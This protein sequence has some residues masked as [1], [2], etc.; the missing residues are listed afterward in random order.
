MIKK[1]DL[2]SIEFD[3]YYNSYSNIVNIDEFYG[4][5]GR[6][7]Y[8]LLAHLSTLF[9]NVDIID[10]STHMGSSSL[11][12]SYNKLN[13]VYTFD[14]DNRISDENK[15][16]FPGN[17]KFNYLNLF[18]PGTQLEWSDKILSSPLIFLDIDPHDG[19]LEY[20][21]YLF[22]K[23]NNY[24][25]LL[26]LDN[27]W[28]FKKMRDN[29]WYK[30]PTEDKLDITNMGHW[31][32]TGLVQFNKSKEFE[33]FK[34][35]SLS[36]QLSQILASPSTSPASSLPQETSPT[37]V[38]AYFDLT[39]MKDAS[40]EINN[41]PLMH[42]LDSSY[43]TL[44]LD[45]N[46]IIYCEE[47]NIEIIKK[48]RPDRL[49]SRTKFIIQHF[50]DFQI[51]G[52]TFDKYRDMIIKNRK[53]ILPSKDGRNTASY[54][55]FCISRYLMLINTIKENPF[56]DK[57]FAWI[58]IC[59]ERMGFNNLIHLDEALSNIRDKFSTCYIDYISPTLINDTNEYFQWGR[60]SMCS[61]FFTGN[62][63]NMNIF[64]HKII[65]KFIE[66]LYMG[67]G[68]ADEQLF[69]PVYFQDPNLFE[70]YYGDYS[71]MITNYAHCYE[72]PEI[73]IYLLIPKSFD[74]KMFVI[75]LNACRFLFKSYM[76]RKI[77]LDNHLLKILCN[78]YINS[79]LKYYKLIDANLL[80]K[81]N[82]VL[83]ELKLKKINL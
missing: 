13:T 83:R 72:N 70:F 26:I 57:H 32:G 44:N 79:I 77:I 4:A 68:H 55:L 52:I 19:E 60:C 56:N 17:I 69:S 75:S 25:G 5:P 15:L 22:L 14:I 30:I 20:D 31:S 53:E 61:G 82:N 10:I 51:N 39:K 54:Y 33:T 47:E 3:E 66:F 9:D 40:P 37:L 27:I 74:D 59:I 16:I 43:S 81:I 64:C 73:T 58:N 12:L 42:Y 63:N 24:Q 80:K 21:F 36:S 23:E 8:R 50:D 1:E 78:Y 7:H 34:S 41:R 11:A 62:G 38:T 67:Y 71:Q 76:E 49:H 48:I 18:D 35:A 45:Y 28:Y 2:S 6:E 46:M 29:F 65:T